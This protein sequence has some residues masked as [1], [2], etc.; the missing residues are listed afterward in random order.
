MTEVTEGLTVLAPRHKFT[1]TPRWQ[2]FLI[3]AYTQRG[4]FVTAQ[5]I[6]RKMSITDPDLFTEEGNGTKVYEQL[7]IDL[8][9]ALANSGRMAPAFSLFDRMKQRGF[10]PSAEVYAVVIGLLIQVQDHYLA[11][12]MI[13]EMRKESMINTTTLSY[14]F[15]T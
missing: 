6:L 4:E 1:V 3:E 8:I 7:Y 15:I 14:L 10:T 2:A 13:S 9:L 11:S 12:E 5:N